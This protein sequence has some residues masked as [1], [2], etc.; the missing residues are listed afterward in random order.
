MVKHR[1]R[2]LLRTGI[3]PSLSYCARKLNNYLHHIVFL[4][5]TLIRKVLE[6]V[7][8]IYY[9]CL[10]FSDP[11]YGRHNP[12]AQFQPLGAKYLGVVI[13]VSYAQKRKDL[14]VIAEDYIL[15]SDGDIRA[16]I[17]IDIEYHG[18]KKATLSVW[19]R[20]VVRNKVGEA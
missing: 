10:T 3:R 12:D 2:G 5:L 4:S 18:S 8:F 17:G 7:K 15:G 6:K 1:C 14:A 11:G 19:R 9:L 16:V 20:G 13:E